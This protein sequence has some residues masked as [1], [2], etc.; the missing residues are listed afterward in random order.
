MDAA[1]VVFVTA[2]AERG[3]SNVEANAKIDNERTVRDMNL[4]VTQRTRDKRNVNKSEVPFSYFVI[5]FHSP[6]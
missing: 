1:A 5:I 6:F 4:S 3:E 2:M